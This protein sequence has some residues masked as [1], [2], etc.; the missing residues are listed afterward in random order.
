MTATRFMVPGSTTLGSQSRVPLLSRKGA[1]PSAGGWLRGA[2]AA[3]RRG[4]K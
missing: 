1:E 3:A 4:K 2:R